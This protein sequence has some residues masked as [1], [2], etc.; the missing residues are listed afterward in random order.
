[1][2]T[3]YRQSLLYFK[4]D[5]SKK[6]TKMKFDEFMEEVQNDILQDK[7]EK[8]WKLYGKQAL[9]VVG[10]ILGA[11][12]LF[13]LQK[14]RE[15]KV[16]Q[17]SSDKLV[18][19]QNALAE[20][21][22]D[23]AQTLL[24]DL[25]ATAYASYKTLSLFNK[26]GVLLKKNAPK[27]E[28]IAVFKSIEESKDLEDDFKMLAKL[29]RFSHELGDMDVKAP[30]FEQMRLEVDKLSK[31]ETSWVYLAKELKGLILF[32]VQASTEAAEIF[33]QL[34]Q[35]PK[36]PQA[37]KLRSQLMTQILAAKVTK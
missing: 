18:S 3:T 4:G 23:E 12:V 27:S 35:D 33:V 17:T 32:R 9:A 24:D 28:V 26:A 11:S 10:V 30:E 22:F 21:K 1:M 16:N 29:L 19:A 7:V 8:Y 14:N 13:T 20:A 31:Q 5:W 6:V 15:E 2:Y 34:I 25:S 37:I 36:T